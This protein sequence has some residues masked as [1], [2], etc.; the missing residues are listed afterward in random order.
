MLN[1]LYQKKKNWVGQ[2]VWVYSTSGLTLTVLKTNQSYTT[3]FT[4][5]CTW[6][7]LGSNLGLLGEKRLLLESYFQTWSFRA[8]LR[9]HHHHHH[10]HHP[11]TCYSPY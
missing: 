7:G 8:L 2:W 11:V 3:F 5:D 6:T 1:K 10:Y 4:T 9:R